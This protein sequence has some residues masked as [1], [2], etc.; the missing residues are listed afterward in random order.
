MISQFQAMRPQILSFQEAV[1]ANESSRALSVE[2]FLGI[3]FAIQAPAPETPR[4][5]IKGF[6]LL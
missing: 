5:S 4:I 1:K 3:A 2:D 6:R